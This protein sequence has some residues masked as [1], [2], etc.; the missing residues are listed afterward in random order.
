[1]AKLLPYFEVGTDPKTGGGFALLT[2]SGA[3]Q[4]REVLDEAIR[5]MTDGLEKQP[6]AAEDIC[7]VE[8][9]CGTVNVVF[10]TDNTLDKIMGIAKKVAGLPETFNPWKDKHGK[11][12][13]TDIPDWLMQL[14]GEL[15]SE[16][17]ENDPLD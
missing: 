14:T 2:L 9:Q 7:K 8:A 16:N 17:T 3:R 6:E 4:L 12:I 13:N 10:M 11:P 5:A 15:P 1:M